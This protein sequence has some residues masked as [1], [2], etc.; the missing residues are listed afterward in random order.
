MRGTDQKQSTV[1]SY[2]S[3]EARIPADHP[4]RA[5]REMTNRALTRMDRKF[6]KLYSRTGRP[7]IAPEQLLRALL[8]QVLYSIRSERMLMEQL[9]YN[10][11]FRWLVGLEMDD[12]VWEVT[13]FTKN[14]N[15]LL[16]GEIAEGFFQAVLEQAREAGLLSDEHFT[17]D[18]TLIEAWASHKSFR[19]KDEDG[20]GSSGGVGS[21]RDFHGER[22][23]SDTHASTTDPEARLFRKGKREGSE[24]VLH[25]TR[26]HG[27]PP[28]PGGCCAD[29]VGDGDGRARCFGCDDEESG[30]GSTLDTWWRQELRHAG[31]REGAPKVGGNAARGPERSESPKRDRRPNH[32]PPGL[33]SEPAQT[34]VCGA[35]LRMGKG[36]RP[37][38]QSETSR[39]PTRWLDAYLHPSCFQPGQNEAPAMS[40]L[41]TLHRNWVLARTLHHIDREQRA[42]PR[43]CRSRSTSN[44]PTRTCGR[45][46]SASC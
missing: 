22:R 13:V 26:D 37:H 40:G 38:S 10:L 36:G 7:S 5:T 27:E 4:L 23:K 11:L 33:R 3:P 1:F 45:G 2:V 46:F 16:E 29:D 25:G 32:E 20:G 30:S 17:V 24:A 15:R 35:G 14:R 31:P 9:E 43:D 19:P 12:R 18:G 39:R 21:E 42:V 44:N 28:R 34:Q 8:L 41:N 6:R